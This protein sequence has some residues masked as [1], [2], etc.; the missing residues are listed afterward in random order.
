M[1]VTRSTS[2]FS[3]KFARFSELPDMVKST[4]WGFYL[5]CREAE[6]LPYPKLPVE[7]KGLIWSFFFTHR[8]LRHY[9]VVSRDRHYA[10]ID[11]ETDLLAATQVPPPTAMVRWPPGEDEARMADLVVR[12]VGSYRTFASS[13]PRGVKPAKSIVTAKY[14]RTGK[15]I[16]KMTMHFNPLKDVLFLGGRASPFEA[17]VS[18]SK[19]SEGDFFCC[20]PDAPDWLGQL[21]TVA[22][23]LP[24]GKMQLPQHVDSLAE[25]LRSLTRLYLVTHRDPKCMLDHNKFMPFALFKAHH[26]HPRNCTCQKDSDEADVVK[27]TIVNSLGSRAGSVT[28]SIVADPY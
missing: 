7:I 28:I 24:R 2:S 13:G 26:P 19:R 15:K 12:L 21:R 23:Q 20:L 6:F 27:Q 25:K 14:P 16:S 10:A 22:L 9:V 4:I 1:P 8:G 18:L 3:R 5:I 11:I 17:L